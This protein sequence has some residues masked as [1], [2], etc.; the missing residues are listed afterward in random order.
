MYSLFN[1]GIVSV[2]LIIHALLR[3]RGCFWSWATA[4]FTQAFAWL[5]VYACVYVGGDYLR[6][7]VSHPQS[8]VWQHVRQPTTYRSKSRALKKPAP[9]SPN[10]EA[11]KL[12]TNAVLIRAAV[13]WPMGSRSRP[14]GNG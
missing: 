5:H 13:D 1:R 4:Q 9:R 14:K 8:S 12:S 7:L 6:K 3:Q 10:D 2:E 11:S